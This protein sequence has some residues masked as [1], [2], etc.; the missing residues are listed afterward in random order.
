LNGTFVGYLLKIAQSSAVK[1]T[2]EVDEASARDTTSNPRDLSFATVEF[3]PPVKSG[4]VS[5]PRDG[6]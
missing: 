2:E 6:Y 5:G 3:L 1:A 4:G